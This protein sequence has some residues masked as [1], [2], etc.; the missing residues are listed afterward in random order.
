MWQKSKFHSRVSVKHLPEVCWATLGLVSQS[1]ETWTPKVP[2]LPSAQTAD[3]VPPD[4]LFFLPISKN[5]INITNDNFV[6]VQI[7]DFSVQGVVLKAVIS[8][9]KISNMS[10]IQSRSQN[11]V[12]NVHSSAFVPLPSSDWFLCCSTLSKLTCQSQAKIWGEFSFDLCSFKLWSHMHIFNF[13]ILLFYM[14]SVPTASPAT[15]RFTSCF[16]N[17]SKCQPQKKKKT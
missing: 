5:L 12:R 10:T 16:W 4:K 7:V 2:Q 9:T 6:P 11:S 3:S 14:F 17:C 15:S 1:H 8:K 13:C